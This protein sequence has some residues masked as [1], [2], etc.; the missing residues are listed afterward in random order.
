MGIPGYL[1]EYGQNYKVRYP[2][3]ILWEYPRTYPR[4]IKTIRFGTP[5]YYSGNT[6][7]PTRAWPKTIRFGTRVYYSGN[8]RVPTRE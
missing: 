2:G 1:P 5:V 4:M 8:S 7:V 3:I 6:Q